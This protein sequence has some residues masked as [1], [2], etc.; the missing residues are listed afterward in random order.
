[1]HVRRRNAHTPLRRRR[2]KTT[3][4]NNAAQT[5]LALR[6]DNFACLGKDFLRA[7]AR[8]F[9]SHSRLVFEKSRQRGISGVQCPAK[10]F[11]AD[12]SVVQRTPPSVPFDTTIFLRFYKANPE[13][14]S[15]YSSV[16]FWRVCTL[17]FVLLPRL[18]QTGSGQFHGKKKSSWA[19]LLHFNGHTL[20][21]A[22]ERRL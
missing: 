13:L 2:S 17:G 8:C 3:R 11:D 14:M 12:H 22:P 5:L 7:C 18:F 21:L 10:P 19:H 9:C 16:R 15:L 4:R 20:T 6:H 1:M